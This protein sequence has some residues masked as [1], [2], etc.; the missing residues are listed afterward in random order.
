MTA[1][2]PFHGGSPERSGHRR[3]GPT[4]RASTHPELRCPGTGVTSSLLARARE[5]AVLPLDQ[6]AW[7]CVRAGPHLQTA[8]SWPVPQAR[9]FPRPTL[10]CWAQAPWAST[11]YLCSTLL[12]A[13]LWAPCPKTSPGHPFP[14]KAA[15]NPPGWTPHS[16]APLHQPHQLTFMLYFGRI[17]TPGPGVGGGGSLGRLMTVST[18]FARETVGAP[19]AAVHR[20][21]HGSCPQGRKGALPGRDT[22]LF[23]SNLHVN[24][25]QHFICFLMNK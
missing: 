15:P 4:P 1:S 25:W 2:G 21:T 7:P 9:T 6:G 23:R 11:L 16:A 19:N 13:P 3:P 24:W 8:P 22:D 20:H 17:C 14:T 5:A 12:P 18:T 10:V